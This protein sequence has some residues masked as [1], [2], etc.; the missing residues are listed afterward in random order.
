MKFH[1]FVLSLNKAPSNNLQYNFSSLKKNNKNKFLS[2]FKFR[3]PLR[4]INSICNAE[5]IEKNYQLRQIINQYKSLNKD[6]K[7]RKKNNEHFYLYSKND[8]EYEEKKK[9]FKYNI[10]YKNIN[11]SLKKNNSDFLKFP[12][13]KRNKET[14]ND[15][16]T[17]SSYKNKSIDYNI[18]NLIKREPSRLMKFLSCNNFFFYQN[19]GYNKINENSVKKNKIFKIIEID[20]LINKNN[21]KKY[22]STENLKLKSHF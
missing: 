6:Y 10:N 11:N 18:N 14:N 8:L 17:I 21:R 15:N 5:N 13:I 22:N 3:S 4:K 1:N 9:I 12:K 19:K 2:P 16:N 7:I 20:K